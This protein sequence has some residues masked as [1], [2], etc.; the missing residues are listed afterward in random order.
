[1]EKQSYVALSNSTS[2]IIAPR[3]KN[4]DIIKGYGTGEPQQ[5]AGVGL[6]TLGLSIIKGVSISRLY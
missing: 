5:P 3:S 4:S 2:T 6:L 1:M